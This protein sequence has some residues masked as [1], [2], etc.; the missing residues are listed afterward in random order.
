MLLLCFVFFFSAQEKENEHQ[1][2]GRNTL[3]QLQKLFFST[4]TPRRRNARRSSMPKFDTTT[5]SFFGLANTSVSTI[6]SKFT[7]DPKRLST[8]SRNLFAQTRRMS[9]KICGSVNKCATTIATNVDLTPEYEKVHCDSTKVA[10][11]R[12]SFVKKRSSLLKKRT[13][14]LKTQ[15]EKRLAA[16]NKFRRMSS[17]IDRGVDQ[18]YSI[19]SEL[20]NTG[21]TYDIE[22]A[23]TTYESDIL[24]FHAEMNQ[25][26]GPIEIVQQAED[27]V[28]FE[29]LCN[30]K[31]SNCP[32]EDTTKLV[33]PIAS[34]SLADKDEKMSS[35]SLGEGEVCSSLSPQS[36]NSNFSGNS[37][38]R[39]SSHCARKC[40]S[41]PKI[42]KISTYKVESKHFDNDSQNSTQ[43]H[44]STQTTLVTTIKTVQS[45]VSIAWNDSHTFAR[46]YIVSV[47]IL[48]F[49]LLMA[50]LRK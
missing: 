18:T 48:V 49:A 20:N 25:C 5:G 3:H 33:S 22:T 50:L 41:Q 2:S 23:E 1:T 43:S 39:M 44:H 30:V 36:I 8:L 21:A 15:K 40:W 13:Q 45:I 42:P 24:N 47:T 11:S 35:K 29:K 46:Y 14:Q 7:A 38:T 27:E 4:S 26:Q 10:T 28:D 34:S 19:G 37:T 17:K 9:Q 6:E 32:F 16:Y 12:K 31:E